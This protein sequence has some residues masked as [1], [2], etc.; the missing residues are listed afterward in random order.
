MYKKF[1]KRMIDMMLSLIGIILFSPL[2]LIIFL[3]IKVDSKGSVIFKHKRLGKNCKPIY[4]L[5]FRTMVENAILLGPQYTEDNDI[6]IT[7]IGKILRKT[8]LDELPQFINVF[9]GDMSIIGPRPDAYTNIPTDIQKIRTRVLPGI[10][11][12]A[13]VNG[14]SNLDEET[15]G[16]YDLEYIEKY[17]FIYDLKIFIK[18]ILIVILRKGTN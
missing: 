12:L 10:T 4:V 8:S 7:K 9:K 6:R 17:S 15:K 2:F 11:G 16:N 13:Q 14:R 1:G 5:K 18:T 3:L